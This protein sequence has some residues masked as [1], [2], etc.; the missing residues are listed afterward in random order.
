MY[1]KALS[2]LYRTCI[3]RNYN[4]KFIALGISFPAKSRPLKVDKFLRLEGEQ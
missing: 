1:T 3:P 4:F 2:Q